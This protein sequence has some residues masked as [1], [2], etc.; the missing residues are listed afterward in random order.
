MDSNRVLLDFQIPIQDAVSTLQFAPLSNNLLVSSWDSI[1]RLYDVDNC[2]LRLELTSEA[3]LLDCC[4]QNESLALSAASDG[5][6]RRSIN[7]KEGKK[8]IRYSCGLIL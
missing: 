5:C 3:A 8:F 1:L 7:K 4:F 2:T 6:I